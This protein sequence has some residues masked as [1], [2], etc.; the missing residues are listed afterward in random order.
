MRMA[1]FRVLVK[2]AWVAFRLTCLALY[3]LTSK[4]LER[5]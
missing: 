2:V 1:T 4:A 3:W 5:R